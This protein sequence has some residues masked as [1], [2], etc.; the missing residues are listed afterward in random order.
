MR[1]QANPIV[2]WKKY[3]DGTHPIISKYLAK[4]GKDF[5]VQSIQKI[6]LANSQNKSKIILIR[7]RDSH[8]ISILEQKD[9]INA[10]KSILNFCIKLEYYEV[11]TDIQKVI[12]EIQFN[13]RTQRKIKKETLTYNEFF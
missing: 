2:D 11:C 9:Y 5:I 7:F 13:K 3:L 4:Y 6:K 1:K 12:T 8:I 10:L